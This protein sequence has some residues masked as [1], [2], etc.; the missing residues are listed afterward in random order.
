M[1]LHVITPSKNNTYDIVWLEINTDVGNFVI[2]PGHAPALFTL[3]PGKPLI[4]CLATGEQQT[5]FVQHA[6]VEVHRE[7][8]TLLLHESV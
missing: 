8:I 6:I 4:I 7:T 5:V 1:Q 2:A 3:A